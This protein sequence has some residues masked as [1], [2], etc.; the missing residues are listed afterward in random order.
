MDG[1]RLAGNFP[2]LTPVN[3]AVPAMNL[4][5]TLALMPLATAKRNH[6]RRQGVIGS[7]KNGDSGKAK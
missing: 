6:A 4:P 7:D 5:L 2:S 3:A 1:Y